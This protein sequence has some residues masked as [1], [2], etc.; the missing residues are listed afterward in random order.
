MLLSNIGYLKHHLRVVM[1]CDGRKQPTLNG[2]VAIEKVFIVLG[3]F[4][5]R[6]QQL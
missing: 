4:P 5:H 2:N 1:A 6:K 3:G